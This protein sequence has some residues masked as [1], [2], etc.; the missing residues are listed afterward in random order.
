MRGVGTNPSIGTDP[1]FADATHRRPTLPAT[2]ARDTALPIR[3]LADRTVTGVALATVAATVVLIAPS[4]LSPFS[5][6]KAI[7][8]V[9][10]AVLAAALALAVDLDRGRIVVPTGVLPAVAAAHATVLLVAAAAS[11]APTLSL[12]GSQG[13]FVGALTHVA[14]VALF[15]V[16]L[17]DP[18]PDR[19]RG[20]AVVVAGAIGV[21]AAIA[22]LQWTGLDLTG[23][24]DAIRATAEAVAGDPDVVGR[25]TASL[26]G[27]PNQVGAVLAIGLPLVVALGVLA[28]GWIRWT[29]AA[30]GL[31][32]LVGIAAADAVQGPVAGAAGLAVL[33]V[34]AARA[35][36]DRWRTLVPTATA[37]LGTVA[38]GLVVAGML[39]QGPGAGLAD[40]ESTRLR[41]V[42][43]G[44]AVE[45]A[46]DQPVLGV[47]PDRYQEWFRAHRDADDAAREPLAKQPDAAHDV[48]LHLFA[49]GG[50]GAGLTFVAVMVL[51]SALVVRRWRAPPGS[52]P[53]LFGAIAGAWVAYHVQALVS[54]D[55]APLLA[56][57]WW[58]LGALVVSSGTARL[59]TVARPSGPMPRLA[60]TGL[61]AVTVATLVL[62]SR[63]V[64]ADLVAGRAGEATNAAAAAADLHTAAALATWEPE[65]AFRLAIVESSRSLDAA[66]AA[67]EQAHARDPRRIDVLVSLARTARDL[68]RSADARDWYRRAL[69]VEP[70]HPD[71]IAEA[72]ELGVAPT[73]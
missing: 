4:S 36:H 24:A 39:G 50:V 8:L 42:Y 29:W 44:V 25:V 65:Y 19:I 63:P 61:T 7:A 32:L 12:I 47:G 62:A 31:L 34:T 54:L 53:W 30:V 73:G 57:H 21:V 66:Y 43:W 71:L 45:M 5:M 16:V 69:V 2:S 72:A 55:T 46:V 9:V 23:T 15:L 22:A 28:R 48:V 13:R 41:A 20:A 14:A 60:V 27:N 37:V 68:G 67:L 18:D 59:R 56:L 3:V 51:G 17:R 64:R 35:R 58:L 49:T 6:P 1:T 11:D 38:A 33:A 40:Q 52:S 10:G 26:L 70:H